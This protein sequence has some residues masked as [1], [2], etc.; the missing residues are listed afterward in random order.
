MWLR[1]AYIKANER[2]L[3]R[4]SRTKYRATDARV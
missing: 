2:I 1:F 3:G 4:L